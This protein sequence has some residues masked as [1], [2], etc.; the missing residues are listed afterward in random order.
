MFNYQNKN[1]DHQDGVKFDIAFTVGI[2]EFRGNKKVD[3]FL[4]DAK[5][6]Q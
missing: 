1:I 3:Y 4:I 6:S 5:E 2:N